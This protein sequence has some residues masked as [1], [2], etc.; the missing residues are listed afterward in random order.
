MSDIEQDLNA[1]LK[2]DAGVAALVSARVFP[3]RLPQIED[4]PGVITRRVSGGP[5]RT[6]AGK[7]SVRRARF[8]VESWSE[9]SQEE[10]RSIDRAVQTCF[11]NFQRGRFGSFFIQALLVDEDT[12]QDEP[13]I[14]THADDLGLF[15]S[16]CEITLFYEE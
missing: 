10:A 9:S 5:M 12:D 2:A 16:F 13:Q 14:P 11:E 3:N 1:I 4:L 15:C 8:Q 6:L 7:S